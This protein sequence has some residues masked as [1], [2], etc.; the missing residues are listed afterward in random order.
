MAEIHNL[1]PVMSEPIHG[2][3][4]DSQENPLL[5]TNNITKTNIFFNKKSNK[6]EFVRIRFNIP[7]PCDRS[8]V[9]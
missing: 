9:I 5:H 1:F 3:W 2:T 7:C 8:A 4:K 6:M